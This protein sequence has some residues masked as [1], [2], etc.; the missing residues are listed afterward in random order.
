MDANGLW[1]AYFWIALAVFGGRALARPFGYFAR[2]GLFS[3]LDVAEALLGVVALV[4]LWGY[5]HGVAYLRPWLW[6]A[7]LVAMLALALRFCF[8]RKFRES[9]AVLGPLKATAAYGSVLVLSVPLY[10]AIARYGFAG[11]PP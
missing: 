1:T 3:G 10:V 5:I 11:A 2:P 8:T 4:G 7:L 9:A 6:Q